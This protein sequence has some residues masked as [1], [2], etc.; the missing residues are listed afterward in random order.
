M[1]VLNIS[2]MYVHT[3]IGVTENELFLA[4]LTN[5]LTALFRYI[6]DLI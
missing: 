1:Y 3:Y 4:A 5:K 2:C 6:F